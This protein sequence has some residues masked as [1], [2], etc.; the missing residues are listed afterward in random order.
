M[1]FD[2]KRWKLPFKPQI[3]EKQNLPFEVFAQRELIEAR[4]WNE[5][6]VK[7]R[8]KQLKW[9]PL[10]EGILPFQCYSNRS[11]LERRVLNEF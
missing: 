10:N 1:C 2:F 8:L 3:K 6:N 4:Q 11:F 7:I 5:G 9:E